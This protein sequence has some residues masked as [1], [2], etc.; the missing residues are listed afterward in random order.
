[1]PTAEQ[2][3]AA[4]SKLRGTVNHRMPPFP[5]N[6]LFYSKN[7]NIKGYSI[8]RFA[9]Q[10]SFDKAR[11]MSVAMVRVILTSDDLQ[12]VPESTL[13]YIYNRL[14]SDGAE[15]DTTEIPREE[16]QGLVFGVIPDAATPYEETK[17]ATSTAPET[18][19]KS[20]TDDAAEK[21]AQAAAAKKAEKEAAKAAAAAKRADGVI[22]TI[23]AA[24]DTNEGTTSDEILDK[25]VE[26]FPDRTREGMSS[27]VKIQ[28]S[29]LAK[30]TNREII[31]EKIKSRGRV[32]KFADRGAVPGE[33][34]ATEKSAP[35]PAPAPT[36][37]TTTAT[38]APTPTSTPA[39]AA[40][41]SKP[42]AGGKK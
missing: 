36:P 3:N 18:A 14:A 28:F 23:K 19:T 24:L 39:P 32:Y 37:S 33:V 27:T 41:A 1:M 5:C 15:L 9:D 20:T 31:N 16:L 8:I 22:G 4:Q 2:R 13:R 30:S 29:R 26:K 10:Q 42:K 21:R 7:E 38:P 6:V 17:M 11:A 34:E 40:P 25:L 12:D 35:A